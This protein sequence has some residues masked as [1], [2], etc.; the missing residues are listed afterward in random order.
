MPKIIRNTI[1][2]LS[3]QKTERNGLVF[4]PP[5]AKETSR[6]QEVEL[7]RTAMR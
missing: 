7:D 4:C 1:S 6:V 2:L 5:S 3:L